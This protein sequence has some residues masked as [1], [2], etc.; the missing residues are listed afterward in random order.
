MTDK[1]NRIEPGFLGRYRKG[2][3]HAT[4]YLEIAG[5]FLRLRYGLNDAPD[6]LSTVSFVFEPTPDAPSAGPELI[7]RLPAAGDERVTL[8]APNAVSGRQWANGAVFWGHT[9]DDDQ[10]PSGGRAVSL[11]GWVDDCLQEM[12]HPPRRRTS[13][14]RNREGWYRP[15]DVTGPD[16]EP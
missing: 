2:K 3:P 6:T 11:D 9:F 7:F 12:I 15:E 5:G 4:V 8:I 10:S 13:R 14:K 16:W 1:V